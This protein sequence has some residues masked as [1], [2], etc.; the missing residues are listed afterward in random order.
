AG[1]LPRGGGWRGRLRRCNRLRLQRPRHLHRLLLRGDVLRG[2]RQLVVEPVRRVVELLR[3]RL[4]VHARI[5]RDRRTDD[6]SLLAQRLRH[7]GVPFYPSVTEGRGEPRWAVRGTREDKKNCSGCAGRFTP[8]VLTA[9]RAVPPP[10]S[11]DRT[12]VGTPVARASS[13]ATSW[14]HALT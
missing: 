5:R 4:V 8:T 6:P 10:R 3:E 11:R 13:G 1:G 14:S 7:E 9:A 2:E 12:A